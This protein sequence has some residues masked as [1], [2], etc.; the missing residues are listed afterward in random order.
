MP[1]QLSYLLSFQYTSLQIFLMMGLYFP[2][3]HSISC[4]KCDLIERGNSDCPGWDR[5]PV[6][7]ITN[8]GDRN[9]FYTHC[10]DVRLADGTVIHQN[11]IPSRPTCRP[12]FLKMWKSSLESQFKT[13]V[14]ITCCGFNECN[15]P[16][17][18][19]PVSK[20]NN[21]HGVSHGFLLSF[22]VVCNLWTFR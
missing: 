21:F 8:L 3:A 5:L 1:K 14:T 17:D 22:C 16:R 10:L 2:R 11:V 18:I 9:G 6:N 20:T 13:N 12:D 4:F 15:G 7:S 19:R